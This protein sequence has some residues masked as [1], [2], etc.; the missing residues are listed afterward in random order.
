M[1]II[2]RR[3]V[4][5]NQRAATGNRRPISVNNIFCR[6]R[7]KIYKFTTPTN[8]IACRGEQKKDKW[9]RNASFSAPISLLSTPGR[10]Y[11][12]LLHLYTQQGRKGVG[13]L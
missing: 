5:E 7:P 8:E 13:A 11:G 10:L 2:F 3:G 9:A 6:V 12:N 1:A 4:W